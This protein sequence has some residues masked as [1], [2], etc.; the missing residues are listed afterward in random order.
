M[1]MI[2]RRDH[3]LKLWTFR[4]TLENTEACGIRVRVGGLT[5]M[6]LKHMPTDE[7]MRIE[8]Q[9]EV[10]RVC[11]E[12]IAL[13]IANGR[14]LMDYME[15]KELKRMEVADFAKRLKTARDK[16]IFIPLRYVDD[17]KHIQAEYSPRPTP[18]GHA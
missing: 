6:D 13:A 14:A 15:G 4:Y 17:V 7:P 5:V 9:H 12:I 8:L 16:R 18:N 11:C 3:D 1:N 2:E 10:D